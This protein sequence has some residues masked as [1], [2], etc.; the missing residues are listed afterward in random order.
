M[1]LLTEIYHHFPYRIQHF[2]FK[3]QFEVENLTDLIRFS[4]RYSY[5]TKSIKLC[6]GLDI[7]D[8]CLQNMV[9]F[10]NLQYL[11]I[12][13]LLS[14]KNI[15]FLFQTLR[16]LKHLILTNI[17]I[18]G[19]A[20]ILETARNQPKLQ[21]LVL[22]NRPED[23]T[24]DFKIKVDYNSI[25]NSLIKLI[26]H[27]YF[28]EINSIDGLTNILYLPKAS[29]LLVVYESDIS[30]IMK[31]PF[32][33]NIKHMLLGSNTRDLKGIGNLLKKNNIQTLCIEEEKITQEMVDI[34]IDKSSGQPKLNY[35]ISII[36]VEAPIKCFD[37]CD[38]FKIYLN[39]RTIMNNVIY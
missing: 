30:S 3:N 6:F 35:S 14:L 8:Q 34:F 11:K 21:K 26:K 7:F 12:E 23:L 33:A 9:N 37:I 15:R 4:Y 28:G 17:K 16:K 29:F 36:S 13:S 20:A 5:K 24:L 22:L 32:M 31:S 38:N 2:N 1:N 18:K 27:G 25:R 39:G 10:P 19:M